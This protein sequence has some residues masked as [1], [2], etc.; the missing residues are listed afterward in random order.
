MCIYVY[1]SQEDPDILGFTSDI[2]GANLPG[3]HGPWKPSNG[4][5]AV[6]TGDGTDPVTAIVRRVGYFIATD[7][8]AD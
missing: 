7:L 4:G 8:S 3:K 6:V 5:A 1:V 2:T